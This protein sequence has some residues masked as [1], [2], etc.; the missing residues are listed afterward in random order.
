MAFGR[1]H[2]V[3][4]N[5]EKCRLVVSSM[6]MNVHTPSDGAIGVARG[7]GSFLLPFHHSRLGEGKP[8][9]THTERRPCH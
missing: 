2:V 3:P 9:L 5:N 1:A 8:Y 7:A 6:K 4:K